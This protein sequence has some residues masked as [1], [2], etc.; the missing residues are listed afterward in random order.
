MRVEWQAT[1]G[2]INA[3]ARLS[4][5]PLLSRACFGSPET[6]A[7]GGLV[8]GARSAAFASPRMALLET[9]FQQHC[10]AQL[11]LRKPN[12]GCKQASSF[13]L[14]LSAGASVCSWRYSSAASTNKYALCVQS[15]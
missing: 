3:P 15:A 1:G 8:D 5:A 4:F 12:Y 9:P 13:W 7:H 10:G 6:R 14:A 2:V 11:C